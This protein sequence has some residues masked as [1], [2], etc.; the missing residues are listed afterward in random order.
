MNW[1]DINKIDDSLNGESILIWQENLTDKSCSRFQRAVYYT[2]NTK[3]S[4]FIKI[5]PNNKQVYM[6]DK[7]YINYDLEGDLCQ[8]THYS[9]VNSPNI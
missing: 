6:Q 1:I 9:I 5:Y 4:S 7:S 2:G 8:I 3:I